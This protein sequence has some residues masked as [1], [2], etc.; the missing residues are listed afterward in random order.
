[1][2]K[3][4]RAKKPKKGFS[5]SDK[6][7]ILNISLIVLSVALVLVIVFGTIRDRKILASNRENI[8]SSNNTDSSNSTS[9]EV[10]S[11]FK[12]DN[13]YKKI[14]DG[15]SVN[16]L[17]LG[18]GIGNSEGKNGDEG[19]WSNLLTKWL[20]DTYNSKANITNLSDQKATIKD[21][22]KSLEANK[23]NFDIAYIIFG[24]ND[25]KTLSAEE[26][27]KNY[28]EVVKNLKE[29]NKDMAI[30]PVI[31]NSIRKKN[32]YTKVIEEVAKENNLNVL[33]MATVFTKDP[34]PYAKIT[35]KGGIFP[36]N[37]GYGLY[38]KEMKNS[39][40][41]NIKQLA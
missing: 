18:D 27:K 36:N 20:Q 32:A 31:E 19:D 33:D 38:F 11:K 12:G 13:P 28:E 16:I 25:E 40:E 23:D 10:D 2:D 9:K 34:E 41:S 1:M 4:R 39:I 24:Q 7:K 21:G 29:R 26:F 37:T 17:V 8:S 22:N 14:N 30:V 5:H 6:S 15:Q 35:T 3:G